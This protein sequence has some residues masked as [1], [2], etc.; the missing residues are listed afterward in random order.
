[1]R[2]T[3]PGITERVVTKKDI[4][5]QV[6]GEGRRLDR[7]RWTDR[8]F[9]EKRRQISVLTEVMS[10]VAEDLNGKSYALNL[11]DT[12]GHPDFLD[13]VITGLAFADGV[14]FCVDVIEGLTE[15][16]KRLLSHVIQARLPIILVLTKFDRLVL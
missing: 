4:T 5:N 14:A 9:L 11:I 6:L 3:H 1:M 15:V 2:E 13:Q 12:P 7:L 8:L 10:L 16:G